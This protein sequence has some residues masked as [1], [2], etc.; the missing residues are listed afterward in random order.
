[1]QGARDLLARV[2]PS[3]LS[4][5]LS[6]ETGT[7]KELAA[8]ALHEMSRRP[9]AFVAINC[10]AVSPELLG[11]QLF[12]HERGSF[13]G[14]LARHIG[15][16]ERASYGTVFLDEITE[17]PMA[18]QPYLLRA[19][20]TGMVTRLG[21]SGEVAAPVRVIA[22]TNRDPAEA[23][24]DGRLRQDL[25][26][27]LADVCVHMPA[28][29]ERGDDARLLAQ[30]LLDRLNAKAGVRKY[31]SS[32]SLQCLAQHDWRGNVRELHSAVH[33]AFL[34]SDFLEIDI[35]VG[36]PA[37]RRIDMPDHIRFRMG[38]TLATLEERALRRTLAHYRDDKSA[39]AQSLGIS[40]RTIHNHLSRWGAR[41]ALRDLDKG[42]SDDAGT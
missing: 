7:G 5:M 21:G 40:V 1:M 18:V 16:L 11:S 34:L 9:G 17:M 13:T 29:R 24:A 25:Y 38:D 19:L 4:V 30:G 33:R 35:E 8:R 10:G 32:T 3:G 39:A 28:L 12:G 22:A 2:A 26:Y 27:R 14:A 36:L 37:R 6:G 15:C 23:V 31:F 42:D 20:E 41:D